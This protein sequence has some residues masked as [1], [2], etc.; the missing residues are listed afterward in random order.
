LTPISGCSAKRGLGRPSRI[1][2]ALLSSFA[3]AAAV[4]AAEPRE[5][6]IKAVF[7]FNFAEFVDW[8]VEA[9]REA[10]SPLVIGIL[11]EDP[12]GAYLDDAVRGEKVRNRTLVVRRFSRVEDVSE[13]QILF[14]SGSEDT[15]LEQI[16]ASLKGRSILTVSDL[17]G[18]SR[19]GGMIRFVTEKSRIRL[20][21][22]LEAAKAA[23]LTISSKL[24]RPA[25]I[26]SGE[27]VS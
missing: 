22:N 21:I 17:D 16:L 20:K 12:F 4:Q 7:L 26:V 6:E 19:M 25:Q 1:W 27:R 8:P 18:F 2:L 10:Q 15:R 23:G 3:L 5:F 13:C 24:L 9:F 11:G 14:I